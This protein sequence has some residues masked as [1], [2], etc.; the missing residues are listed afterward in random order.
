VGSPDNRRRRVT[1][2]ARSSS[3]RR[4]GCTAKPLSRRGRP[5]Q[6]ERLADLPPTTQ[7]TG[8]PR[9]GIPHLR[10]CEAGGASPSR[11]APFSALPVRR[12]PPRLQGR[13][14]EWPS[15]KTRPEA[16]PRGRW[17]L[18]R[19]GEW[20]G[21]AGRGPRSGDGRAQAQRFGSPL[22]LC[23]RGK[24]PLTMHA[25]QGSH[26]RRGQ[27]VLVRNVSSSGNVACYRN[28]VA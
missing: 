18:H 6:A 8:R 5:S 24:C 13:G 28:C 14:L 11:K 16:F 1:R 2:C 3:F 15:G 7:K 10:A 27:C 25:D 26:R 21:V 9:V 12:A 17:F 20:I 19:K 4:S 23:A 22:S